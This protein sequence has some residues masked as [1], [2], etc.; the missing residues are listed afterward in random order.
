LTERELLLLAFDMLHL[1]TAAN[2]TS[3]LAGCRDPA[4][5]AISAISARLDGRTSADE[6]I[7]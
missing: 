1:L 4:A 5:T 7:E 6:V 2:G 3:N